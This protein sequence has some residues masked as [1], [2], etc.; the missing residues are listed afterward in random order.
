MRANRED[1]EMTNHKRVGPW[2]MRKSAAVV[3]LPLILGST[4]VTVGC[5]AATRGGTIAAQTRITVFRPGGMIAVATASGICTAQS[6]AAP[7]ADAYRC[8][9]AHRIYDP[10][11]A[12]GAATV[13]CPTDPFDDRGIVLHVTEPLPALPSPA[14]HTSIP[15]AMMLAGGTRCTLATGASDPAYPYTCDAPSAARC[16]PPEPA[17][18]PARAAFTRCIAVHD[19]KRPGTPHAFLVTRAY[20]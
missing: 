12:D 9:S 19:G 2:Q 5:I 7:R 3:V 17:V 6:L 15:W 4:G 14:A 11:F 8:T 20:R 1:L 16:S 10:C 13:A 18:P